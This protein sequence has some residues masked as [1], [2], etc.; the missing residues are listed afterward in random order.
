MGNLMNVVTLWL[1]KEVV[2]SINLPDYHFYLC[3]NG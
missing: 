2:D 1:I 3:Y